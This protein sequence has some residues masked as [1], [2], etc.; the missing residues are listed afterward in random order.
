MS[1]HFIQLRFQLC[2][3]NFIILF[4]QL[5]MYHRVCYNAHSIMNETCRG[6]WRHTDLRSLLRN[7][8]QS[9]ASTEI[10]SLP[11]S[12]TPQTKPIDD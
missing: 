2:Q 11:L 8:A 1:G 7:A 5:E 4:F 9:K 10:N 6:V 3:Q 12:R